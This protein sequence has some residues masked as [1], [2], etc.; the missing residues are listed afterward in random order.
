MLS[1]HRLAVTKST[2]QQTINQSKTG[3][4]IAWLHAKESSSRLVLRCWFSS[5]NKSSIEKNGDKTRSEGNALATQE[6]IL[7]N[8]LSATLSN[9][10]AIRE[11]QLLNIQK[12]QETIKKALNEG[13]GYDDIERIKE[14]VI[15]QEH[16][17]REA[18]QQLSI[19]RNAYEQAIAA[20]SKIQREVNDLLQRKNQW[21]NDD[22]LRITQLLRDE[23]TI[24]QKVIATREDCHRYDK[25]VER[26]FTELIQVMMMR[27][28]DEHIWSDKIR[29]WST[30]GTF[31]LMASNVALL[32]WVQTVIEPRK[33]RIL[34]DR[35]KVETDLL[36]EELAKAVTLLMKEDEIKGL[37]I[38]DEDVEGEDQFIV[39]PETKISNSA[40][41]DVTFWKGVVMGGAVVGSAVL[42]V[43]VAVLA[44]NF[45][46]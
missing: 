41:Y 12:G 36:K 42:G 34:V 44:A 46:K 23:Q 11:K 8:K 28:H 16:K 35:I 27:Y 7:R 25:Q 43:F 29:N 2:L 31:A 10:Q 5:E 18:R 30:Y 13:S 45:K 6:N 3:V 37:S 40:V 4:E 9:I 17:L 38:N 24:E 39:Q 33:R 14:K 19:S 22:F 15:Q 21:T 20:Q 1:T 26:E 32:I